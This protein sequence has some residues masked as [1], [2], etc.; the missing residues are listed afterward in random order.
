MLANNP[1]TNIYLPISAVATATAEKIISF[2]SLAPGWH[3]GNGGPINSKTIDLAL[4]IYWQFFLG[5][6]EETDAFPGADGEVM[7]TAYFDAH[8]LEVIV[9]SDDTM[10][11]TYEV[12]DEEMLPP[13]EHR[14]PEEISK[15]LAGVMRGIWSTSA[16]CTVTTSIPGRNKIVSKVWHSKTPPKTAEPLWFSESVWTPQVRPSVSMQGNTIQPA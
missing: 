13:L 9:E 15:L 1:F 3:Y 2:G 7:V 11:F 6:L 10:S 16:F 5:G 4:A 8:Y 14:P 12:G